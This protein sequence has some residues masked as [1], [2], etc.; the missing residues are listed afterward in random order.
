LSRHSTCLHCPFVVPFWLTSS[1]LISSHLTTFEKFHTPKETD[2]TVRVIL[3]DDTFPGSNVV[4]L[5]LVLATNYSALEI[6]FR[7]LITWDSLIHADLEVW[8]HINK[9]SEDCGFDFEVTT[10]YIRLFVNRRLIFV[11]AQPVHW[12]LSPTVLPIR[13][14]LI[15]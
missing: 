3:F 2:G 10:R 14:L 15:I 13:Q 6:H 7:L 12:I 1:L 11:A 8:S 9:I 4:V 5:S